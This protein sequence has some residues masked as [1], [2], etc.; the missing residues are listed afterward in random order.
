MTRAK[1]WTPQDA[2]GV[3]VSGSGV[4]QPIDVP[5]AAT[6]PTEMTRQMW[7]SAM[8]QGPAMGF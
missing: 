8:P 2:T 5:G 7:D 6:T 1:S 3:M 4:L